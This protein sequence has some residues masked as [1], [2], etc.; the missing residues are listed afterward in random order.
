VQDALPWDLNGRITHRWLRHGGETVSTLDLLGDGF[1]LL[2][3]PAETRW[4]EVTGIPG[5]D[6]LMVVHVLDSATAAALG[7]EATGARLLRPDG[8]EVASW[9]QLTTPLQ[10]GSLSPGRNTPPMLH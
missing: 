7:I 8:Q 5:W 6:A 1:T 9:P 10:V 4:R 2:A 3:G